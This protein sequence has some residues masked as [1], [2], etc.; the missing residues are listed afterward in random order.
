LEVFTE[1]AP[2]KAVNGK[3]RTS[4]FAEWL[5]AIFPEEPVRA[6]C[7]GWQRNG[8]SVPT[9]EANERREGKHK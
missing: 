5:Y 4:G 9:E 8:L 6:L 2:V 7:F 3:V 1:V